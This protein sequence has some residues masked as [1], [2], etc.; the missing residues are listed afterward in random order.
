MADQ[1]SNHSGKCIIAVA[2]IGVNYVF[3]LVAC[4]RVGFD[5][6]YADRYQDSVTAD[7]LA[8]LKNH[9]DRLTFGGG[10]GGDLV[11]ILIGMPACLRLNSKSDFERYYAHL[12]EGC[13]H[14][15][16]AGFLTDFAEPIRKLKDWW[17]AP[18][19]QGLRQLIPHREIIG[20][21]GEITLR[22]YDTHVTSVWPVER[23]KLERVASRINDAFDRIDRIG[24]WEKLVGRIF[25][26]DA[27]NIV[28]CSAIQ[29]G[30][31]ANSIGYDRVVFYHD[32]NIRETLEFI[33][34]EVGTHLLIDDLKRALALN[35]Y[36]F[37]ALYEA[38][39]CLAYHYNA[40]LLGE[41]RLTYHRR[42][43][44]FRLDGYLTTY[45]GIHDRDPEID[46]YDLLLSGLKIMARE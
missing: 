24:Q 38:Y 33:S 31:N 45:G 3:H 32:W 17:S 26:Y 28:L 39:E 12:L 42:M 25:K 30:P 29:N 14:D 44:N 23:P 34:H 15:N 22:N 20:G 35:R 5:S 37:P 11:D 7:D 46:A 43:H 13:A 6:D 36:E 40:R 18:D 2:E 4:A 19:N 8:F 9:G 1:Q 10:S 16:F 27:Y 41:D 21:L